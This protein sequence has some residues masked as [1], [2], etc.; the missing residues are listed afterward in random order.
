M[1]DIFVAFQAAVAAGEPWPV[2]GWDDARLTGQDK[3]RN[4][5]VVTNFTPSR[6]DERLSNQRGGEQYLFAITVVGESAMDISDVCDRIRARI[7]GLQLAAGGG[8]KTTPLYQDE[9]AS[10]PIDVEDETAN[11]RLMAVVDQWRC[12]ATRVPAA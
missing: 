1:H 6:H 3:P 10:V 2:M 11:P 7:E 9:G 12:A 4:R 8:A 5:I